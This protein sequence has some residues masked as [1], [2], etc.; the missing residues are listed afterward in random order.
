M[1]EMA[2]LIRTT[3]PNS[4]GTASKRR[5]LNTEDA[6]DVSFSEQLQ[7]AA[8]RLMYAPQC[9]L[10]YASLLLASITEIVWISHP[11][12]NPLKCCKLFYP[13]STAFFVVEAYLTLGLIA[14]TTLTL[15]WQRGAFWQ[16]GSNIFD[17]V[18]CAMSILSFGLYWY[19][20][21]AQLDELVLL[22]MVLWIGLRIAR[23]TAILRKIRER[24]RRGQEVLDVA[25][26]DGDADNSDEDDDI[27][28]ATPRPG[29]AP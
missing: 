23:L 26:N 2:P 14:E 13:Q 21:E 25:F 19:G 11:W 27:E 24:R 8:G 20:G 22:V 9:G 29:G 4:P 10:F 12:L 7:I 15:L 18:V 28:L 17:A 5:L 3:E 1:G 6:A 16:S